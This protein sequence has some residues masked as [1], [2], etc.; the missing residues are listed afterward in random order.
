MGKKH[1]RKLFVRVSPQTAYNLEKLAAMGN[2]N[3]P[4]RVVDKLVRDKMLS[5]NGVAESNFKRGLEG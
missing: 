4:G 2:M 3:S 1:K 5:F